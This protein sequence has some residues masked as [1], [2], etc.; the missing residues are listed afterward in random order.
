MAD[1]GSP[2]AQNVDVSP[3][4]GIQTLSGLLGL[5]SQQLSI[6]GQEQGLQGQ[7]AQVQMEQQSAGQRAGIA[8][9]MASF[10][11]TK[12][13]GTDG[14]LDL[15]N[16]LTDPK[17][18][19]AAGDQFPQI[20]QQMIQAKQ[21]QLQVK[22]Q[23]ANLNDSLRNQFSSSVGALRTDSDVVHDTPEGRN[24]VAQAM[25]GFAQSGGPDAQRIAESL[26]APL[27]H[28]PPGKLAQT[29]SNFQLLATPGS[30]Q[31]SAQ[32]PSYL[33]TG[34]AAVN[35]NP[36]AAGG[37]VSAPAKPIGMSIPPGRQPF[38]D[39][40]G[41]VFNFNPQNG[42]YE[43]AQ[44]GGQGGATSS[45][46]TKPTGPGAAAPGDVEAIK[47]QTETNFANVNANRQGAN[48]APQQLDQIRN[49]LNLAEKTNTGGDWTASRARIESNLASVIPGLK[50][51]KDDAS[52]VQELDKFLERITNDS[53]RVLGQNATTDAQRDSLHRQN[54]TTG[55]T[56]DAIKAVLKYG[57]AQTMA[58]QAKG[59]AQDA[60]LKQKGNG[61]TN[62]HDFET[63]W[64]QSYDPVLFQLEAATPAE[65]TKL[66][67]SL[68]P[69][70]AASLASKRAGLKELGAV[71]K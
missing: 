7:A 34:A 40:F 14:T 49:A 26:S 19:Q 28:T 20:M 5:K 10:D 48:A 11:P 30:S 71:V 17:L 58:M 52:K 55:Y 44:S 43:P 29:I 54:A 39:S 47:S 16:V 59:N 67:Q 69:E 3:T 24:K 4:K 50:S 61:I 37:D 42:S 46:G 38:T 8:N 18:R 57:A 27:A 41:R 66:I 53:T 9:F 31:A 56:N 65:R 25:S 36:Q 33:N 2:V 12:H 6:K 64:R 60:W 35:I 62:Q 1:F 23:F 70:E 15:D 68:P 32:A 21:G 63:Q 22:Q 13:I 45:G 51:A